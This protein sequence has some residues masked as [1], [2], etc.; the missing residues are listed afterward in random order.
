MSNQTKV[1]V[2]GAT[3]YIGGTVLDALLKHPKVSDFVITAYV[4]SV[5]TADKVKALGVNTIG[6]PASVVEDAVSNSDIVI[7]CANS[8][9]VTFVETILAGARKAYSSTHVAPILIHTSGTAILS[10]KA[11]GQIASKVYDD[12]ADEAI[13]AAIPETAR[14]RAGDIRLAAAHDEG[15]VKAYVIIPTLVYGL[16]TGRFVD[17]GVQNPVPTSVMLLDAIRQARGVFGRVGPAKNIYA[18][19]EVHDLAR[20]YLAIIDAILEKKQIAGGSAYYTAVDGEVA[21]AEF[22]QALASGFHESGVTDTAAVTEITAEEYKKWPFLA[23]LG[24]NIRVSD[25]RSRS[26]GWKPVHTQAD[27]LAKTKECV[28]VY[29]T[30]GLYKQNKLSGWFA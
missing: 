3:G 22:T 6:G 15:F 27:F 12:V 26:L 20:L 30:S 11:M 9:D 17:A 1:L 4:R 8:D 28:R 13:L 18:T 24:D 5:E 16:A 25:T 10:D 29:T 14:H 19:I 2:L 7:N 23:M 21:L